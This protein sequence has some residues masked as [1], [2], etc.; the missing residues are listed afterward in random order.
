MKKI[1]DLLANTQECL[2][3]HPLKQAKDN[4]H[5]SA[6]EFNKSKDT[7]D[8]KSKD[9]PK[10]KM[11]SE[12]FEKEQSKLK[13]SVKCA[14]A[15]VSNV[16]GTLTELEYSREALEWLENCDKKDFTKSLTVKLKFIDDL[17][18][19]LRKYETSLKKAIHMFKELADEQ[20][21]T[22]KTIQVIQDSY[23]KISVLLKEG[24]D[25]FSTAENVVSQLGKLDGCKN[26]R[27]KYLNIFKKSIDE[28][29]FYSSQT[30]IQACRNICQALLGY[31]K[32]K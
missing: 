11:D 25:M 14:A 17:L 16:I 19:K 22:S 15:C 13:K 32:S 7:F 29:N 5:D 8:A 1:R 2:Q 10:D 4:F 20:Q 21:T 9:K 30:C 28:I 27:P 26:T 3:R 24:G 12:L 23:I 18:D 31:P 6:V